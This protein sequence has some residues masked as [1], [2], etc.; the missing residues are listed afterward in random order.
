MGKLALS[1]SR[2]MARIPTAVSEPRLLQPFRA[3]TFR[4]RPRNPTNRVGSGGG[5]VWTPSA[6]GEPPRR[7]ACWAAA[8]RATGY[9]CNVDIRILTSYFGLFILVAGEKDARH[10]VDRFEHSGGRGRRSV[11]PIAPDS[12]CLAGVVR[13]PALESSGR[14]LVRAVS[15]LRWNR[16]EP[17]TSPRR[18][19]TDSHCSRPLTP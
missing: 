2:K 1:L 10:T 18:L 5:V 12:F 15:R 9:G 13:P 3:A 17:G 6:H 16:R 14:M 4:S 11:G 8:G 19:A 7:R